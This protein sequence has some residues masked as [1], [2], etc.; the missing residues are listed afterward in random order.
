MEQQPLPITEIIEE[1]HRRIG[2]LEFALHEL[3]MELRNLMQGVLLLD[4]YARERPEQTLEAHAVTITS[5]YQKGMTL[6]M[7]TVERYTELMNR[8]YGVGSGDAYQALLS[9]FAMMHLLYEYWHTW[10]PR[11][12]LAPT[13]QA[14]L[15]S[16]WEGIQQQNSE[17]MADL[18]SMYQRFVEATGSS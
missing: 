10:G 1:Q 18:V 12:G 4:V 5:M 3:L 2:Q 16:L 7:P 14:E 11:L 17:R 8:P 15:E 13:L 9:K 6:L